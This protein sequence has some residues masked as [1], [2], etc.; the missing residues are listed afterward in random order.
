MFQSSLFVFTVGNIAGSLEP[1]CKDYKKASTCLIKRVLDYSRNNG[2]PDEFKQYE[3][4]D[5]EYYEKW[6]ASKADIAGHYR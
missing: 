3:S 6:T 1:I 5:N 2:L 4:F